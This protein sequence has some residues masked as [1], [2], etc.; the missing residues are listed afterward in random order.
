MISLEVV[1]AYKQGGEAVIQQ[2]VQTSSSAKIS[3][4]GCSPK[5]EELQIKTN[6]QYQ[7]ST[8]NYEKTHAIEV[9]VLHLDRPNSVYCGQVRV[10]DFTLNVELLTC[11]PQKFQKVQNQVRIRN[12]LLN[13]GMWQNTEVL[14]LGDLQRFCQNYLSRSQAKIDKIEQQLSHMDIA[15]QPLQKEFRIRQ[16]TLLLFNRYFKQEVIAYAL[17]QVTKRNIQLHQF[18]NNLYLLNEQ[19]VNR[20]NAYFIINIYML[21]DMIDKIGIKVREKMS[22]F[23]QEQPHVTMQ[24]ICDEYFDN[25]GIHPSFGYKTHS[26]FTPVYSMSIIESCRLKVQYHKYMI[27]EDIDKLLFDIY[28]QAKKLDFYQTQYDKVNEQSIYEWLTKYGQNRQ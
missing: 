12:E 1:A 20:Q 24:S 14:K 10:N 22:I 5:P 28:F 16:K 4:T 17:R 13:R 27:V 6:L 3:I 23:I 26:K 7:I 15:A 2:C 18:F 9:L 21:I 8:Q 25:F 19:D 11:D